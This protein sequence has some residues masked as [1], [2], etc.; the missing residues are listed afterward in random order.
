MHLPPGCHRDI[1]VR[2]AALFFDRMPEA[3]TFD[4]APE[5]GRSGGFCIDWRCRALDEKIGVKNGFL[6]DRL[7]CF[8]NQVAEGLR[9]LDP[10]KYGDKRLGFLAYQGY[11][12]PPE[13]VVP[14]E[15]VTVVITHTHWTFCDVHAMDDP[16]CSKNE[17]F[18]RMLRGW[19]DLT[20][21]VGV[22]DYFGHN[23]FYVPWPLWN[24]TM[25]QHLGYYKDLGVGS[26][27]A[28][29]QQNWGTQ[30]MNFYAA[31]KLAWDTHRSME[32]LWDDFYVRFYGPTAG[33]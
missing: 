13:K 10:V 16:D 1:A 24:T 11:I 9:Q 28:E 29:S 3:A 30:G 25:P 7:M 6:T 15:M 2:K 22:Y 23:E 31:A 17:W 19:V 21:R 27:I 14:D 12:N 26:F 18:S 4:L 33:P 32:E 5:D 20:D 8:C